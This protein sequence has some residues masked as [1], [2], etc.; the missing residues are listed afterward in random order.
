MVRTYKLLTATNSCMKFRTYLTLFLLINVGP[1][2]VLPADSSITTKPNGCVRITLNSNYSEA[3]AP[4]SIPGLL[5]K[6]V[7][8]YPNRVALVA[9]PDATGKRREYTYR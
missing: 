3:D 2:Q 1:D 8:E 9:R 5:S 6:I 4:L 7:A